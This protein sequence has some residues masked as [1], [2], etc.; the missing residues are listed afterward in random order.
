MADELHQTPDERALDTTAKL[1]LIERGTSRA[2]RCRPPYGVLAI[3]VWPLRQALIHQGHGPAAVALLLFSLM[4]SLGN[5]MPMSL[6]I[7]G[8]FGGFIV[9]GFLVMFIG[10]T[11]IAVMLTLARLNHRAGVEIR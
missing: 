7:L 8:V 11:L 6:T 1:A 10:A 4:L 9:F 3:A 2:A 5:E